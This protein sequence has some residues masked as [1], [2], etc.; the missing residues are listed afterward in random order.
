MGVTCLLIPTWRN[1]EALFA[2]AVTVNPHSFLSRA[3]LGRELLDKGRYTEALVHFDTA[4]SLDTLLTSRPQA[5]YGRAVAKHRLGDLAA[6]AQSYRAALA[7]D[8]T[9]PHAHN[10]FGVLL[11]QQGQTAQAI[12]HFKA[13]I[14]L[15]PDF[16]EAARNLESAQ[17]ILLKQR[18]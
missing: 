12:V 14:A 17:A 3:G 6:A 13:A 7:L 11:G 10:N 1:S 8:E 9:N 16:A 5:H 2:R 18:P 15:K 4:I